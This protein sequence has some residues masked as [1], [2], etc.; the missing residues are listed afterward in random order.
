L[1]KSQDKKKELIIMKKT[2]ENSLLNYKRNLLNEVHYEYVWI[3]CN[4]IT[5]CSVEKKLL[6]D[7]F[8]S[9]FFSN[10]TKSEVSDNARNL[11]FGGRKGARNP[12]R[13]KRRWVLLEQLQAL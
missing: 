13:P 1:Q 8:R 3:Y 4:G 11:F 12:V 2:E 6:K 10:D 5:E 7:F 9:M